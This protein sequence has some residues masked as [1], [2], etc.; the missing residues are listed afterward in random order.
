MAPSSQSKSALSP[1]ETEVGTLVSSAIRDI[2]ERKLAEEK[3]LLSEERFRLMVQSVKDYAIFML[4]PEG[5]VVSWNEGA[6]RIK[7]Y[8][9]A[10]IIGQHF[11]R[12]YTPADLEA[13]EPASGLKT[14]R[15][16]TV[17]A[18]EKDGGC[19]RTAPCFGPT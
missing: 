9:A 10:E 17:A 16:A 2:T 4:D 5:H 15:E 8:T 7:G 11:S 12:F 3:M 14:A 6:Q 13:D 19:A 1:I 18:R